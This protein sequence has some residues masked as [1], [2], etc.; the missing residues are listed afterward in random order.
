MRDAA[1]PVRG[2][3][4]GGRERE[5]LGNKPLLPARKFQVRGERKRIGAFEFVAVVLVPILCVRMYPAWHALDFFL[6]IRGTVLILINRS[7]CC[8]SPSADFIVGRSDG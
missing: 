2:R 8:F 6:S 3:V 4:R 1:D 5:L 7:G